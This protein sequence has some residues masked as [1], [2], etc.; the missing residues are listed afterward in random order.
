MYILNTQYLILNTVW[1]WNSRIEGH[2]KWNLMRKSRCHCEV[3][4]Q[5]SRSMSRDIIKCH[6]W[7]SSKLATVLYLVPSTV[8]SYCAQKVKQWKG[9]NIQVSWSRICGSIIRQSLLSKCRESRSGV[10]VCV[11][12]SV[13]M[14]CTATSCT[15]V[16]WCEATPTPRLSSQL[17]VPHFL[18]LSLM[19]T[20]LDY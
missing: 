11:V 7:Q 10:A 4:T 13:R 16:A 2:R 12:A 9:A 8:I 18:S 20:T 14:S 1:H 3:K 19:S 5:R 17:Y 6:N 15:I